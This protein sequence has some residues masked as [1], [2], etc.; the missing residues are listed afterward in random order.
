[1][2]KQTSTWREKTLELLLHLRFTRLGGC[3]PVNNRL[4]IKTQILSNFKAHR[5]WNSEMRF[6]LGYR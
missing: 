4:K 6:F 2:T 3:E 1:M 5:H